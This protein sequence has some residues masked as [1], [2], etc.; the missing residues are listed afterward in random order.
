M[1]VKKQSMRQLK[2]AAVQELAPSR[3]PNKILDEL[4]AD[5]GL[6]RLPASDPKPQY[7]RGALIKPK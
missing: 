5:M 7:F 1:R 6:R 3:G 4:A 2:D